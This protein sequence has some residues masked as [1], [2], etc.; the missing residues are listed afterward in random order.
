MTKRGEKSDLVRSKE[1]VTTINIIKKNYVKGEETNDIAQLRGILEKN[2]MIVPVAEEPTPRSNSPIEGSHPT[3]EYLQLVFPV[4]APDGY[5]LKNINEISSRDAK[6]I[7]K[8]LS[9][10]AFEDVVGGKGIEFPSDFDDIFVDAEVS[11]QLVSIAY[12]K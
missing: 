11:G 3:Y 6:K 8:L 12:F 5:R 2:K 4:I 1:T 7:E 9:E 10:A